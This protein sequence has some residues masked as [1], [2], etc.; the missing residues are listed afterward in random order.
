MMK[1]SNTLKYGDFIRDP[2]SFRYSCKGSV[3]TPISKR[4]R[5]VD[6][7]SKSN[8]RMNLNRVSKKSQ[9]LNLGH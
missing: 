8:P 2:F 3:Y 6:F 1:A 4:H 5:W 7:E 9:E